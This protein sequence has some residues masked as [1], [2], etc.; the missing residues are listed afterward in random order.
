MIDFLREVPLFAELSEA[1]LAD[2]AG[3]VSTVSLEPGAEL[4]AEG[5]PGDAAFI[6]KS[7]MIEIFKRSAGREVLLAVRPAGE[8]LGEMSLLEK[9]KRMASGRARGRASVLR[10]P[11]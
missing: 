3:I 5:D 6:I 9:S 10:S 7:G 1:D 11:C 4:F 2:L 8:V